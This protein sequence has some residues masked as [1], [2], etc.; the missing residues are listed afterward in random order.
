MEAISTWFTIIGL[1]VTL[2]GAGSGTYGVWLSPDQ[3]I[4]RGVS[5]FAGDTREQ[6]LQLPAVQNLL[7][8]SDF[9]LCGFFLIG[10]GTALQIVGVAVK[11]RS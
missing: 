4:E 2:I 8:Q 9:A 6:L 3:A 7:E 1:V 10:V 11:G 5:R